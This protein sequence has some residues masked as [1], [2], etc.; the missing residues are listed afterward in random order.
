[1]PID[2]HRNREPAA[3]QVLGRY[4]RRTLIAGLVLIALGGALA[5]FAPLATVGT[6]WMFGAALLAAGVFDLVQSLRDRRV[7]FFI[8]LLAGVLYATT[9]LLMLFRPLESAAGLTLMLG[10]MFV[11]GGSFRAVAAVAERF[12]SWGWAF[13]SGLI[14]VMLGVAILANWPSPSLYLIGTLLG[15]EIGLYG[16]ALVALSVTI[17]RLT[18]LPEEFRREAKEALRL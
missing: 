3:F 2:F 6:V 18:V 13:A 12:R 7:G 9:G 10:M 11:G 8:R 4:K 15:I 14:S 1:M 16:V 5:A 17:G